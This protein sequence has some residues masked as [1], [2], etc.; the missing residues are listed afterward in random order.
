MQPRS[1]R[2]Q[3]PYWLEERIMKTGGQIYWLAGDGRV[4]D[5]Q[6]NGKACRVLNVATD[7]TG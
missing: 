2:R 4:L 6:P 1:R 5:R 3:C 7:I